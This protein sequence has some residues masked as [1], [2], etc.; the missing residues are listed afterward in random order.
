MNTSQLRRPYSQEIFSVEC[1]VEQIIPPE[2]I[3]TGEDQMS[4]TNLQVT[5]DEA[6][7]KYDNIFCQQASD[8]TLN[9]F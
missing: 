8:W 2:I 4:A 9:H 3:L 5:F 1:R 6:R 7:S